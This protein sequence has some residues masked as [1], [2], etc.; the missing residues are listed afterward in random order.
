MLRK[1]LYHRYEIAPLRTAHCE[2]EYR[3]TNKRTAIRI[4]TMQGEKG[5]SV[6]RQSRTNSRQP[7]RDLAGGQTLHRSQ[8]TQG[9]SGAIPKVDQKSVPS[10]A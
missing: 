7:E 9:T 4:V 1:M 3:L 2:T 10:S 5:T 8:S 6:G